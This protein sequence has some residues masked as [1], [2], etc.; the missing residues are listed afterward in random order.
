M[1][2]VLIRAAETWKPIVISEFEL[3]QLESLREPLHR[4]HAERT[5]PVKLSASRSRISSNGRT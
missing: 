2:A 4:V 1:Y 5:A 3:R